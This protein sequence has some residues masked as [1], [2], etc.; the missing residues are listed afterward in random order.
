MDDIMI[1][2]RFEDG[3]A[4]CECCGEI[5]CVPR[6]LIPEGAKEGDVLTES[7]NGYIVDSDETERKRAEINKLLNDLWE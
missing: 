1:I 7:E 6:S 5:I 3:F 4:V 2:D